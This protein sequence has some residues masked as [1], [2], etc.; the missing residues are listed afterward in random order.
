MEEMRLIPLR[1]R[2]QL[3]GIENN[4]RTKIRLRRT[5]RTLRKIIPRSAILKET[6]PM[7]FAAAL[8]IQ[9]KA[10]ISARKINQVLQTK[11]NET[12]LGKEMRQMLQFIREN[13][14][15]KLINR[16]KNKIK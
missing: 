10:N 11:T 7:S 3:C 16:I 9:E 5:N 8:L 14:S 2:P 12:E 15:L 4:K 6:N 13:R 1:E